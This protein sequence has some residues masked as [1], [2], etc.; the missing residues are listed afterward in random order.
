MAY[1]QSLRL[2]ISNLVVALVRLR[3]LIDLLVLLV[4]I[5]KELTLHTLSFG[6]LISSSSISFMSKVVLGD[7]Q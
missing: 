6:I 2:D 7:R 4:D 3:G 5:T 1:L